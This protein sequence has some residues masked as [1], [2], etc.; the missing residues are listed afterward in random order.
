MKKD[1][2][3][4][5][6]G[7]GHNGLTAAAYLAKAGRKVLVLEKRYLVGGAAVSE[8][9]Y[10]GFK[11][12]VCSYVVS[13]LRPEI[14]QELELPKHGLHLLPM[15]YS[16][17]PMDNGDYLATYPDEATTH[18]EIR[19]HSRRDADVYHEFSNMLYAL[20]YAVKPILNY[21]PPDPAN[22]GLA[23]LQI[24]SE[25]GKHLQSMG[26]DK[27]HWLTKIL[28]MSAYDFLAEWFE[29]D[30]MISSIGTNGIIGTMLG[31]KSPGTAYVLLHH[32]VGE[33]DG[34]LTAWASQ[35]GG[36]GEVSNAIA[37]AAKS[38]GVEIRVNTPVSQVIVKKGRAIGVALENGDDIYA[39][40]VI[41]GADPDITFRKLIDEKELPTEIVEAIDNFK[42]RGS[43]GKVNLSLDGLPEFTAM[44]D[45]SLLQGMIL[46]AP[47]T[48]F[49]EQAYD[50]AKYDDFSKRP[51]LEIVI[52][53]TVDPTMAPPGKHVMSIFVQ[54]ASYN[55]PKYGNRD[56]Q[57][58]AFG[59]AVLDTLSDYAPNFR[60]LILHTQIRTPWDIED[61]IGL[62]QGNIF[63]G[64]LTLDQLF[65]FRP[66]LGISNYRTPIKNYYQCG[67][68]THPGGGVTGGPGRLAAMRILKD[69]N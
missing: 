7:G 41:S 62:K 18:E 67:S 36:T 56:Q 45:K 32:Y 1:Y 33:L 48:D 20:A 16:F 31:I 27:F 49:M 25:F 52:P 6:V 66:G 37:S 22:P 29:S 10:P 28:T 15:D 13:L 26:K 43:S 4:I 24:L 14:I 44:K 8:E 64:E 50:D 51:Y 30:I 61:E 46:I 2:D 58:E 3:A 69:G 39:N 55:M 54:Y 42:Y 40:T 57:R 19:R 35:K 9:I 38:F 59:K 53:T 11:Y 63:G 68:G 60:D 47:S 5:V 12:S 34:A 17:T 23:G 21:I 65:F